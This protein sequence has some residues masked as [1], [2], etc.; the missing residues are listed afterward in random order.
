MH[1]LVLF[2]KRF[3]N[4]IAISLFIVLIAPLIST[5]G[6]GGGSGGSGGGGTSTSRPSATSS[7]AG[8]TQSGYTSGF[9]SAGSSVNQSTANGIA[10][11]INSS[12]NIRSGYSASA[13]SVGSGGYAVSVGRTQNGSGN[14]GGSGSTGSGGGS[15]TGSGGIFGGSSSGGVSSSGGI[16]GGGATPVTGRP[17]TNYGFRPHPRGRG[18]QTVCITWGPAPTTPTTPTTP[19]GPT[20]PNVNVGVSID[21][22]T[23]IDWSANVASIPNSASSNLTVHWNVTVDPSSSNLNCSGAADFSEATSVGVAGQQAPLTRPVPGGPN[24]NYTINCTD[25]IGS[26]NDTKSVN[27]P[28]APGGLALEVKRSTDT[29]WVTDA[30]INPFV[31]GV[32]D[33][34]FLAWSSTNATACYGSVGSG[35]TGGGFSTSGSVLKNS[36][37]VCPVTNATGDPNACMDTSIIEP[38]VGTYAHYQLDCSSLGG[39]AGAFIE[40][41]RPA[42]TPQLTITQNGT[43]VDIVEIDTFVDVAWD[44]T[45]N[46]HTQCRLTGP[47][48]TAND[49][50]PS[51]S[52]SASVQIRGESDFVLHCD[53]NNI[54]PLTGNPINANSTVTQTINITSNFTET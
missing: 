22:G 17:C 23:T 24:V 5:A 49:P 29:T 20:P 8:Y 47:N 15:G 31:I 28:S 10:N 1:K 53:S 9:T 44:V 52:G 33:D 54:S 13:V 14:N 18:W 2:S 32:N 16:F 35:G 6:G 42:P 41:Q 37:G 26:S 38:T 30:D 19:T 43:Q 36:A 34:I 50:L 48:W 27:I 25:S 46:D 51:V 39:S 3:R 45:G 40:V 21:G 4:F 11:S 12:G 7:G